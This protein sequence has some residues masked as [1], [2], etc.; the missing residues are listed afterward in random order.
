MKRLFV[1]AAAVCLFAS[2]A[3]ATASMYALAAFSAGAAAA[4]PALAQAAP[5]AIDVG[6]I[7]G[8]WKPY[9]VELVQIAALAIVGLLAELMRRQFNLTIE[10][11]HREALQTAITN[12]AGLALNKLGNSLQGKTVEVGSPAV[13]AAANYVGKAAPEALKKFGIGPE[14]LREKI[15][16]KIPQIANTTSPPAPVAKG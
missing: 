10:A 1:A 14:D 9:V 16:A 11:K 4:T 13:A 5:T 6:G 7:F 15:V 12:A 3:L 8:A 2:P